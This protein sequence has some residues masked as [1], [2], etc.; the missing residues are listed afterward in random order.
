MSPREKVAARHAARAKAKAEAIRA[1]VAAWERARQ[2][3]PRPSFY[4]LDTTSAPALYEALANAKDWLRPGPQGGAQRWVVGVWLFGSILFDGLSTEQLGALVKEDQ[5]VTNLRAL[6]KKF[7]EEAPDLLASKDAREVERGVAILKDLRKPLKEMASGLRRILKAK[8]IPA[9]PATSSGLRRL[10]WSY[11]TARKE[12]LVAALLHFV[13]GVTYEVANPR[14]TAA[15][16][17]HHVTHYVNGGKLSEPV[18]EAIR[19]AYTRRAGG[20]TWTWE[21]LQAIAKEYLDRRHAAKT[22]VCA[23]PGCEIAR[24]DHAR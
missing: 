9:S 14:S 23:C 13:E 11:L 5:R 17:T 19:H 4:G 10:V 8:V 3:A 1:I 7:W 2:A 6:A 15:L 18:E 16:N 20:G 21:P 22:E 12:P 24:G